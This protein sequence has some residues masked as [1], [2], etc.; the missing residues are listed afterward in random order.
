MPAPIT[1]VATIEDNMLNGL[2]RWEKG[3]KRQPGVQNLEGNPGHFYKLHTPPT[4]ETIQRSFGL[5]FL[6]LPKFERSGDSC[7]AY[8]S[9]LDLRKQ[10][11]VG[12]SRSIE[13]GVL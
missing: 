9:Q 6:S 1:R 2:G 8:A 12:K 7:G 11:D 13:S 10:L 3:Q 5:A 4:D